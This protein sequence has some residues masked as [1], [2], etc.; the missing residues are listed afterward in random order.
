MPPLF[1]SSLFHGTGSGLFGSCHGDAATRDLAE[2]AAIPMAVCPVTRLA[3]R[4]PLRAEAW[5]RQLARSAYPCVQSAA[6]L[7]SGIRTG[8]NAGYDGPRTGVV[9]GPNLISATQHAAAVDKNVADELAAGRR[10]GPY[11]V[12]PFP[13]FR[14][15]PLGVVLKK[16]KA[17][18][19]LIHHLSWPRNGDNVNRYVR[20][21]DVSLPAFDRAVQLLT[22]MGADL[23]AELRGKA[24]ACYIS[25]VDIDA[26]YRC[27]PVR[28][29][30]WPL[31]GLQWQDKLYFD[32]VMQF[33]LASATAIFEW[34]SSA[35]EL[36]ARNGHAIKDIVHYVDDFLIFAADKTQAQRQLEVLLRLFA[37]LGLPVSE[38]KVDGPSP[39]MVFLG[40]MFDAIK[41]TISLHPDR[42]ADIEKLL[43][44]WAD[45]R[46][47]SRA[48][49]QSLIGVLSFA[50]Q[51][52]QSSRTFLR[53]M[54]EQLQLIP[55]WAAATSKY[56]L[57]A[58]FFA[59]I[60]W[61]TA[62]I[63]TANGKALSH[64][65]VALSVVHAHTDA[66]V[67]GYGAVTN[68]DWY[69]CAWTNAEEAMAARQK[70]DSMPWKELYA[71]AKTMATFAERWRGHKVVI[72]SDCEPAI[73]AW[74][75]GDS[76]KPDMASLLRTI[77]FTCAAHDIDMHIQFVAGIDNVLADALSRLQVENF[78]ALHPRHCRSP[79]TCLPLPIHGW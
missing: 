76:A 70:R 31:L 64:S 55:S 20:R 18:P 12:S 14:A 24:T 2:R 51:V 25:K 21:F 26:A 35:A 30:D 60:Q 53:R 66:C 13:F 7:V 3:V 33:G 46:A 77:L 72:H 28:P 38:Q 50:A 11:D 47:A 56:P 5:A 45:K 41:L 57:R 37:D 4:S 65:C 48:E 42:V 22:R 69:S 75:K 59:D 44:E 63:R 54:I 52:V 49:L 73:K 61:W 32:T 40:I 23:P 29:A 71:I 9:L 67:V 16:G 19:R 79:V 43:A 78:K 1:Y 62:F 36:I 15:N 58:S 68:N 10:R 6:A 17:K 27:I 8:V 34:Y 39:L 74:R